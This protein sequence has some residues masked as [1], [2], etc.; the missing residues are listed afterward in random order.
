MCCDKAALT[1]GWWSTGEFTL[2]SQVVGEN[3]G[4]NSV[5]VTCLTP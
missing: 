4:V 5:Q 2:H 1:M 3:L